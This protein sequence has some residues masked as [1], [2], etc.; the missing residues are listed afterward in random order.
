[1]YACNCRNGAFAVGN[2]WRSAMAECPSPAV[3]GSAPVVARTVTNAAAHICVQV[4]KT[5]SRFFGKHK[6]TL[7]NLSVLYSPIMVLKNGPLQKTSELD[8][9][10]KDRQLTGKA[11]PDTRANQERAGMLR[12]NTTVIDRVHDR[13]CA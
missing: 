10:A 2:T 7:A 9:D 12:W 11:S 4:V 1:M 6:M 5:E 13:P 3:H 8:H